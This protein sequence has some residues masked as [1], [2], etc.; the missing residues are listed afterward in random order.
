MRR[1]CLA[2]PPVETIYVQ[3]RLE[4]S[5]IPLRV[6]M[7]SYARLELIQTADGCAT[8]LTPLYLNVEQT[9]LNIAF[10]PVLLQRPIAIKLN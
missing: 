2:W 10:S 6:Y 7:A 5:S 8:P 4:K 3:G 1:D 9:V